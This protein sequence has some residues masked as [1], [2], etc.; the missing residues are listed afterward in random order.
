MFYINISSFRIVCLVFLLCIF[1]QFSSNYSWLQKK[2]NTWRNDV[3]NVENLTV[4][5][6]DYQLADQE[7]LSLFWEYEEV[8][9]LHL[10]HLQH[11]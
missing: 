10:Q 7:E 1:L 6:K 9:K 5:E 4:W 3:R 2:Y 8:G 11:S